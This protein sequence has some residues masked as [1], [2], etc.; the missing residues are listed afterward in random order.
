VSCAPPVI[1]CPAELS[2]LGAML[3]R[4]MKGYTQLDTCG[5]DGGVKK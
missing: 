5:N 4:I 1:L 3:S 2:C